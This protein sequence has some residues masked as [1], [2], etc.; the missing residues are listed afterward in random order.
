MAVKTPA[1]RPSKGRKHAPRKNRKRRAG[2]KGFFRR[3]WWAFV[4]VPLVGVLGAL[5]T[6]YYLY[7]QLELPSTPP[8]LQ[9]SYVYDRDGKLLTTLHA[10]V[11]RTI[12]PIDQIPMDLRNAV[13]AAEDKGFYQHPGIDPVGIVRAAW[14]DLVARETVQGGSTITQ[15]VVKNVYAGTY[16]ED[17]KTGQQVYTVPPRTFGQKVRE[18]LLAMKVEREFTKDEILATYLN[19]VYFG[20]GAYGVQAAA[21]TYWSKDVDA[22]TLLESATLAGLIPSPSLFDPIE[23]PADAMTRRNYVLDRMV[24][25]GYLESARAEVLKAKEVKVDPLENADDF[26]R[27]T[28]YFLDYTRRALI[29]RYGEAAVFGGGLQVTTTLDSEMQGYAEEAVAGRLTDPGDPEAALVAIDPKTGGVL[30]MVGGRNWQ[31][32]QVN[33]ATGDGGTG[34]QAGSAFKVFTLTAAME[35]RI[36]LNSRWHGPASIRIPDQE[37]YTNGEPWT[38][39]NASDSEAGT[40]TLTQATAHSVNTVFAQLVTEVGPDAVVDVAHRMGIESPLDPVC[41]ITLGTQDVTPLEMTDA[42]AT[43]AAR[44]WRHRAVPL[45]QVDG[46]GGEVDFRLDQRGRQVLDENDA[47]LVTSALQ[48]VVTGG[49][50]TNAYIGRPVAGK[51]GTTQEYA[52]AWFCGYTPQLAACVWVGY[53]E[54]R[55]PLTNIHGY[56]AVY[57]GTIPALIW[58]DFMIQAMRG[59]KVLDFPQPSFQG[60][61]GGPPTPPPVTAPPTGP[62]GP[63]APTGPTGPTAPTGPTG[64]TAPTGPTG[65]TAP[66]GPTGGTG[67]QAN[68]TS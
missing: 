27:K 51:T 15:Q 57:G 68:D 30:A 46:P 66:T 60:Y 56:P 49:T 47:D 42:Y 33:L 34:R 31:R 24:A 38:V 59:M 2:I 37:C 22:L 58:H 3:W 13:V 26:P 5:A 12:V 64:P 9:T 61:T 29:A 1:R 11:D 62:T 20:H 41:S 35:D 45:Q 16:E 63:T 52:D 32:S 48:T 53:P 43:L 28:G 36:D 67:P 40:F 39:G 8:P 65:P 54:G 14:T 6:L 50:G 19:T 55:I 44:G 18:S 23:H 10:G 4:A 7:T 17:P 21:Q 25:D